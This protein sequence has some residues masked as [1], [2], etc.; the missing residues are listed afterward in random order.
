MASLAARCILD[1]EIICPMQFALKGLATRWE[2]HDIYEAANNAF[3]LG[4]PRG[5][6]IQRVRA[7]APEGNISW[8][9]KVDCCGKARPSLLIMSHQ[10]FNLEAG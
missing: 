1:V 2:Q 5:G 4:L 10:I 9:I 7:M 8:K 3:R 6:F